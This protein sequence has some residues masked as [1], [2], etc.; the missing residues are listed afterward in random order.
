MSTDFT[1]ETLDPVAHH[2]ISHLAAHRYA[3]PFGTIGVV[4][5]DQDKVRLMQLYSFVGQKE[6]I[7]PFP[8]S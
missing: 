2:R 3:K 7:G 5:V 6:K 4:S 1:N 8:E